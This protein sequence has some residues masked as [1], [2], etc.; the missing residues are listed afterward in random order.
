LG[1]TSLLPDPSAQSHRMVMSVMKAPAKNEHG[2]WA[3]S[4]EV[5]VFFLTSDIFGT[6][7]CGAGGAIYRGAVDCGNYG[8]LERSWVSVWNE[9][10][11]HENTR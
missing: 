10:C 1:I 4:A 5:F 8:A 7:A 11:T 2:K 9:S 3:V 6:G